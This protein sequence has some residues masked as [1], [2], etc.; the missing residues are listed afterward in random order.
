M[1]VVLVGTV[2]LH[3]LDLILLI[4]S[5]SVNEWRKDGERSLDLWY[6]CRTKNGGNSCINSINTEWIQAVQALMILATIFCLLSLILFIWQLFTLNKGGRFFFTAIFQIFSCL[7]VMS[8]AIIYTVMTS[9]EES[10]T[11]SY[12]FAFVLAWLAFPLTLISGL[13]YIILRKKE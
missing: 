7:F 4:I 3:L 12:G 10:R 6:D 8:G 13:I 5:T 9:G 2:I 1:L 11:H